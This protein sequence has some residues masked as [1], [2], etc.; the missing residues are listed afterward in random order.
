MNKINLKLSIDVLML[1][2]LI[3]LMSY[4]LIGETFHEIL[5]VAMF[6]LFLAHQYFNFAWYKNLKS[7]RYNASRLFTTVINLIIFAAMILMILSGILNSQH[8]FAFLNLNFDV[9]TFRLIHLSLSYWIFILIAVHFGLHWNL[10]KSKIFFGKSSQ[11]LAVAISIYGL[12]AMFKRQFA[13]YMF[14]RNEY[15]F[16]DFEENLIFFFA[17]YISVIILFGFIGYKIKKFF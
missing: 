1:A 4:S 17:D 3:L 5:G 9:G 2:I 13:D 12:Y 8:I 16:L 14:L 10:I 6:I 7:G 11:I 15:I